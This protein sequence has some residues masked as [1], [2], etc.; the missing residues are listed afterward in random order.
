MGSCVEGT[1]SVEWAP[2]RAVGVGG[3]RGQTRAPLG[4]VLK[5]SVPRFPP[6]KR[7]NVSSLPWKGPPLPPLGPQGA[8]A[9]PGCQMA[10]ERGTARSQRG[11]GTGPR[12]RRVTL[13]WSGQCTGVTQFRVFR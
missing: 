8:Q 5:P 1:H 2:R 10:V 9:R 11:G 7:G 6:R 4:Q 12:N 13:P 3:V